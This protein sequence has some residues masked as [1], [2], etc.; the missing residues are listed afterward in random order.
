M[1]TRIGFSLPRAAEVR[2]EVIDML[3]RQVVALDDGER[4]AGPH[5]IVV[6][7]AGLAAGVYVYRLFVDDGVAFR[8]T[9]VVQR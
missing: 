2:L 3:G 1:R 7:A 4:P 6:P 5:E 9:F 8:R